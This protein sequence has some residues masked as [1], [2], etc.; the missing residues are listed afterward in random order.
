MLARKGNFA[1]NGPF[2]R[3]LTVVGRRRVCSRCRDAS[4]TRSPAVT[5]RH[6]APTRSHRRLVDVP[7]PRQ[8]RPTIAHVGGLDRQVRREGML[9]VQSPVPHVGRREIAVHRHDGARAAGIA[10]GQDWSA[11]DRGGIERHRVPSAG[12]GQEILLGLVSGDNRAAR[13]VASSVDRGSRW[14]AART[15]SV[16]EGDERL[17]VHR[18][19]D[20]PA[21]TAQHGLARCRRCP[22][23]SPREDRS[24]CDPGYRGC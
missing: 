9:Q 8:I 4:L 5:G 15:E 10:T 2:S 20:Q 13:G 16:V 12:I 18:F 23:Q 11:I 17:P 14:N 3:E 19:I 1:L 21:A 22:T 6:A 24:S 7:N